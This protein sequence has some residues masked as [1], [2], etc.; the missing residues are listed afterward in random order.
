VAWTGSGGD[1]VIILARHLTY[2]RQNNLVMRQIVACAVEDDGAFTVP[3]NIWPSWTETPDDYLEIQIG[4]VKEAG[5]EL[6]H[7]HSTLS[8][9]GAAWVLGAAFM[10]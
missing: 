1:Y 5:A 9:V 4:R 3:R 8:G 10:Q 7:D 2:D 6:P